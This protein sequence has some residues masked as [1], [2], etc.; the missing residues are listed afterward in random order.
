[1]TT[2]VTVAGD[3][4]DEI[5][6]LHYGPDDDAVSAALAAV[7]AANIGLARIGPSLPAGTRIVLPDQTT[8]TRQRPRLW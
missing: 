4:L 5:I 2:V 3:T 7:L 6:A 8:S 1:M